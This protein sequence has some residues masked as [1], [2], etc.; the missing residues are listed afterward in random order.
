MDRYV[1]GIDGGGT[2]F[3]AKA[4]FHSN[5]PP[6]LIT[7]GPLNLCSVPG[8]RIASALEG[9][10]REA[11][12]RAGALQNCASICAG[13]A[14]FSNRDSAMFLKRRI[15]EASGCAD[16]RITSDAYIA[17]CGA[18]DAATGAILISGTGSIC[19]GVNAR[20]EA[21]RA[22][23]AGHLIDDEGSGYAIGRDILSAAVQAIDGRGPETLLTGLLAERNNLR[24]LNEI[25]SFVYGG[26]G[27]KSAI[28]SVAPLLDEALEAGDAA[29][30]GIADRAVKALFRMA[31]AVV[32]RLGLSE[33]SIALR[34][35]VVQKMRAI[36]EPLI[37]ALGERY[38]GLAVVSSGGD[39][40]DGAVYLA[41]NDL[42]KG[43]PFVL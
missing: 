28:A 6:V 9:L 5:R 35:G 7:G 17:L 4:V 24:D 38:P 43:L 25:I 15:Q 31:A 16:V 21:W 20:G 8:D 32:D 23:G 37:R 33:G 14:G 39:A 30:R 36:S 19:L 41:R 2:R 40:V 27:D 34:G 29:A 22:G 18:L 3:T 26:G 42:G 11:G 1:I 12:E 13:V 10:L